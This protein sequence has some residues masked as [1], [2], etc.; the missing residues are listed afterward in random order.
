MTRAH[1]HSDAPAAAEAAAAAEAPPVDMQVDQQGEAQAA[2]AGGMQ[3]WMGEVMEAA[4]APPTA[5]GDTGEAAD[6]AAA[7]AAEAAEAEGGLEY[8]VAWRGYP[9]E[10]N[11]WEPAEHI[12]D[13]A[14]IEAF[15]AR[16]AAL[17][18]MEP[19]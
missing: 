16:E 10:E 7:P 4:D 19:E 1:A 6:G 18:A 15:E 13:A 5:G 17:D 8:L 3:A 9:P 14:L 12:L 11:T 2:A